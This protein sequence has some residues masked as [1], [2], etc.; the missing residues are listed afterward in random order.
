MVELPG[1]GVVEVCQSRRSLLLLRFYLHRRFGRPIR[2]ALR[3]RVKAI[4]R[5]LED[6]SRGAGSGAGETGRGRSAFQQVSTRRWLRSRK[7]QSWKPRPRRQR[8][9]GSDR[10][11]IAKIR[12]QAKREIESAGKAARH[13]LRRFAA[14]KACGWPKRLLRTRNQTRG[15]RAAD[16]LER[17][18][19]WEDAQ[20]EFT[21]C[22]QALRFGARRRSH[23]AR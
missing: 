4:K 11:E 6:G 5:E 15:R 7:R 20:L 22:S 14:R 16:Q 21:D 23:R 1:L 3:S 2:E 9:A 10:T 8:L 13:E 19:T 18:G 17:S 12:E